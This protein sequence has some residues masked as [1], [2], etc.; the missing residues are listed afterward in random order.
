MARGLEIRGNHDQI[1]ILPR[2]AEDQLRRIARGIERSV[3]LR[4]PRFLDDEFARCNPS[5]PCM[6]TTA[7]PI[8]KTCDNV[9][10]NVI[11]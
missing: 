4:N 5:S 8:V 10:G 7:A 1:F 11:F 3:S 9:R 2:H 6:A